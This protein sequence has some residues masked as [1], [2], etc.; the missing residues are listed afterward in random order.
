MT[1]ENMALAEQA[2]ADHDG[3]ADPVAHLQAALDHVEAALTVYDP[4]HMPYNYEKATRLR[5]RLRA[6]L[7]R[8]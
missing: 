6:R 4:V 7:G 5:D 8:D 2:I 1:R 3:T